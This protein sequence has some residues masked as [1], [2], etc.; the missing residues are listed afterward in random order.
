MILAGISNGEVASSFFIAAA[1][2]L[3]AIVWNY[4]YNTLFEMWENKNNIINRSFFIRVI[5]SLIFESGFI[6]IAVPLF[7][8]WYHVTFI[9]AFI[10][11]IGIILFFLIYTF[12]FTWMFD[13]IFPKVV[14]GS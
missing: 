4:I 7:M 10:M 3:I 6:L 13:K 9:Q 1:L 5:H 12:V 14:T 2:S 11:E 8:W